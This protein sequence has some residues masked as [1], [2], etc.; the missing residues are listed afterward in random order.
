M[1]RVVR[2]TQT[3]SLTAGCR[4]TTEVGVWVEAPTPAQA[5]QALK[6]RLPPDVQ[7]VVHHG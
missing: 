4:L 3:E 6:R 5:L 7:V 1:G 2:V